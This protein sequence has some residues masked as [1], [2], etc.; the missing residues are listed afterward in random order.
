MKLFLENFRNYQHSID[1]NTDNI[2]KIS[3]CTLVLGG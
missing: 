3:K 2:S 1:K